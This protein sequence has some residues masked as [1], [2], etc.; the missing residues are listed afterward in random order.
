MVQ[1]RS[2]HKK[3]KKIHDDSE[4]EE[5]DNDI[6]YEEYE[7][8]KEDSDYDPNEDIDLDS[9]EGSSDGEVQSKSSN[10]L[11]LK[12]STRQNIDYKKLFDDIIKD[13][14]DDL[15]N[16]KKWDNKLPERKK[17][18][19]EKEL[20]IINKKIK[21]VPVKQDILSV[22]MPF[23]KK[24]NMMEKLY[25]LNNMERNTFPHFNLKHE[26]QND[27]EKYSKMN[28]SPSSYM[29]YDALEEKI[30]SIENSDPLR[31]RILKSNMSFDTKVE[32]FNKY[33]RYERMHDT[34]DK[35]K[36]LTWLET[37]LDLP[38]EVK[39]PTMN[40]CDDIDEFMVGVKEKLDTKLFGMD[41]AKEQLLHTL[42]DIITSK[43]TKGNSIIFSG[44]QGVGK[45]ELAHALADAIDMPFVSMS[46]GGAHD[47][48]TLTGHGF[49]Y[50]GSH[51][52]KFVDAL[53][54]MKQLNGIIFLD[55]FDKITKDIR[56]QG[57][58]NALLH[59]TDFTQNHKFKDEFMGNGFPVD[60]SNIFFIYSINY[61][62]KVDRTLL[63]R[64]PIIRIDG[65]TKDEKRKITIKHLLP[66]AL[67]GIGLP[68]DS[69]SFDDSA[70]GFIIDKTDKMYSH[71]T[72]DENGNTGVRQLKHVIS[73]VITK[74]NMLNS[75]K[76]LK[77]TYTIKD[78]KLPI[79]LTRQHIND[80]KIFKEKNTRTFSMYT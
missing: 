36:L 41:N 51:P 32:V 7:E 46:M 64:I 5:S 44:P 30:K 4:L 75:S 66:N 58:S 8:Y 60:L 14:N 53:I 54:K 49:C 20:D 10:L 74:I 35:P 65:Y 78:F 29:E 47:A 72:R 21:Y 38:T 68:S 45:T 73:N 80:L 34:S 11:D 43:K 6:S 12:T 50:T 77:L 26:I 69:V 24:C 18:K 62:S 56:G 1:T 31:I 55:E 23:K 71:D 27:I 52:G 57:V 39:P 40:T 17:R 61:E 19:F 48:S 70:M 67:K 28:V 25:I 63:D 13:I 22:A 3:R 15:A 2:A 37:A 76:R 9:D 42:N 79:V 33:K 16:K 59:A